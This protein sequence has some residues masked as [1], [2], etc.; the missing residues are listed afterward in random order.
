VL[1]IVWHRRSAD[2]PETVWRACFA[3]PHE[4]RFW[5]SALEAAGIDDQ[6]SFYFGLLREGGAPIGIVPAFVFDLPL[7]LVLPDAAGRV[8]SWMQGS[9]LRKLARIRTFFIGNVAGEE[10][11]VGLNARYR[12]DGVAAEIHAAAR[13]QATMAEAGLLVWKDFPDSDRG[14]LDALL[15]RERAFRM[16][17]YPG[18]RIALLPGGYEA[19]LASMPTQHRHK[20]R[21][22]LRRGAEMLPLTTSVLRKPTAAQLQEL[23]A[24]YE[25]TY[26]RGTTK[27]ERL[28]LNFF[29]DIAQF[30]GATFVV[31]HYPQSGRMVGFMLLFDLGERV[32]NQFIGI[33][34]ESA[35]GAYTYFRLFAAA[36]DWAC[37][38]RARVMQSGQ[39][40]YM[41]KLESGHTLVPLWNYC[42]HRNAAVNWM[43]RKVAGRITW[44][45]LDEQLREWLSAY[46]SALPP[47]QPPPQ[48][49]F[50]SNPPAR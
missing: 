40:G 28:T 38:T 25:Q 39:T 31:L 41:A 3:P 15:A 48:R 37:T 33:D 20:M 21:K 47:S 11:H 2:I 4:G 27:F 49:H 19:C 18:T 50:V 14:A 22:K 6:F 9:S 23:F 8:A 46:P 43:F 32:I 26:R 16:P 45:T 10:G 34:Y 42:E 36:Y 29:A 5:F 44:H 24:L 7:A 12:L 1:E 17:S 13:K 30:D 35:Q